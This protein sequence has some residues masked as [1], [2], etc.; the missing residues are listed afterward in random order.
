VLRL[1]GDAGTRLGE[2]AVGLLDARVVARRLER[3]VLESREVDAFDEL[4]AL[5]RDEAVSA[6]GA[7]A[8]LGV[9]IEEVLDPVPRAVREGVLVGRV[10][11]VLLTMVRLEPLAEVERALLVVEVL[12]APDPELLGLSVGNSL[13]HFA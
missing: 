3:A 2:E 8:R 6:G 7:E 13:E 9:R 1:K 12:K 11:D 10:V 4:V 5:L